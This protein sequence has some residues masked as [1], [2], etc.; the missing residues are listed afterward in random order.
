VTEKDVMDE[1]MYEEEDDGLPRQYRQLAAHL[2]TGNPDFNSRLEA[3]LT[4]NVAMR[5]ALERSISN[6]YAQQG[7][8][9]PTQYGNMYPSPMLAHQYQQPMMQQSMQPPQQQQ[10]QHHQQNQ[11]RQAPYPSPRLSNE[12]RSA[13]F[14]APSVKQASSP[15]VAQGSPTSLLDRRMSMPVTPGASISPT[16][17]VAPISPSQPEPKQ[18]PSFPQGSFSQSYQ[19]QQPHQPGSGNFQENSGNY[20]PF[21]TALPGNAAGLLGS[22]FSFN[23]ASMMV[24]GNGSLPTFNF[25][26]Q[27]LPQTTSIG[28]QQMYPSIDGL[29]STLAPSASDLN[30]QPQDFF[31]DAICMTGG[32]EATPGQTPGL[33]NEWSNYV[34]FD[35]F[36]SSSQTSQT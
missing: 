5:S 32:Q 9:Y 3:Y 10:Q 20:G 2:Q 15:V 21:S 30:F 11:Y 22:T 26:N 35:D 34:N 23:D 14:A 12:Q 16:N 4:A 7:Q 24:G 28:K 36:P 33:D 17:S 27:P 29:N 1:E 19:M 25:N 31:N 8:Q 18:K 13:S 6:S